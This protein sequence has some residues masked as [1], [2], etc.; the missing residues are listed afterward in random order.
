MHN[1]TQEPF[2]II[3]LLQTSVLSVVCPPITSHSDIHFHQLSFLPL[4][5]LLMTC[6]LHLYCCQNLEFDKDRT[7]KECS[8]FS[9]HVVNSTYLTPTC[10]EIA[11]I[12]FNFESIS[13]HNNI[14]TLLLMTNLKDVL[15]YVD[16]LIELKDVEEGAWSTAGRSTLRCCSL[17]FWLGIPESNIQANT[18]ITLSV[19]FILI[20]NWKRHTAHNTW[21]HYKC[22]I[23]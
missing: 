5:V 20:P 7:L 13:T 1:I 8:T 3:I 16:S 4:A 9:S 18:L 15:C 21:T 14:N 10:I 12:H 17:G 2:F 19:L 22:F 23:Y 6:S 11:S